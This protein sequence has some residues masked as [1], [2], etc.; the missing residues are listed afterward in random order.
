ME[1]RTKGK[2]AQKRLVV[3]AGD[4]AAVLLHNLQTDRL[5]FVRQLRV[6]LIRHDEADSLEI[7]AGKVDQ[8]ESAADAAMREAEEE[9]G[10]RL[11]SLQP[12]AHVYASPGILSE[13]IS[14][15][16]GKISEQTTI[17]GGGGDETE[18][19]E[20]VEFSTEEAFRMLDEGKIRD[21]KTVVALLWLRNRLTLR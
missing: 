1:I 18:E 7:V 11:E 13:K 17:S 10:H 21:G 19:L 16:Y 3:E 20:F 15:F 8:G 5:L 9:V 4:A 2:S 6:P 12:I 14:L